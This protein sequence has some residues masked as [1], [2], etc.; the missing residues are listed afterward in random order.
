LLAAAARGTDDRRS[1]EEVDRVPRHGGLVAGE[2]TGP[3]P[4]DKACKSVAAGL[5]FSPSPD[6][7][8]IM[9]RSSRTAGEVG[10]ACDSV[11]RTSDHFKRGTV[12]YRAL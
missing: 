3:I 2:A 12:H 8:R 10:G 1:I 6:S 7:A 11:T 4:S 5:G 9:R